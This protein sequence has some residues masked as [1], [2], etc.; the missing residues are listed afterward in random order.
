MLDSPEERLLSCYIRLGVVLLPESLETQL[1][2]DSQPRLCLDITN[3]HSV[4]LNVL[5]Y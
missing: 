2:R 1:R 5:T 3:P 4:T